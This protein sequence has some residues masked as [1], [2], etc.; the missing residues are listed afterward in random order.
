ML[1][2]CPAAKSEGLIHWGKSV[3]SALDAAGSPWH[4][5][6][7]SNNSLPPSE[8][9]YEWEATSWE[10]QKPVDECKVRRGWRGESSQGTRYQASSRIRKTQWGRDKRLYLATRSPTPLTAK[11]SV[12]L[13]GSYRDTFRAQMWFMW[14]QMMPKLS[15]PLWFIYEM[16]QVC[17]LTGEKCSELL[18]T[19][20]TNLRR[21]NWLVAAAIRAYFNLSAAACVWR[22]SPSMP[23]ALS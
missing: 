9:K 7:T 2:S 8:I 23:K 19:S 3:E 6:T 12:F 18:L 11:L 4:N 16:H 20:A 21:Q 17:R 15:Y 22:S 10:R 5:M 1:S 14:I 13:F